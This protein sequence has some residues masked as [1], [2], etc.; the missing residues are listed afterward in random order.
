M[1]SPVRLAD[2]ASPASQQLASRAAGIADDVPSALELAVELGRSV[3][4]PGSRTL[5]RWETLATLGAADLTAARVVEPHLDALAILD[6]AA[7][8]GH[9]VDLEAI[10]AD[11]D[12]TWGVFAAEGPGPGV[13]A[14]ARGDGW[15][16]HGT[17]PWCSLAD[18][19]SHA[20]LT[21]EAPEGRG[22]FAVSLRGGG[23][24]IP[25]GT[26][27]ARGLA[28]V[29]SGPVVIDEVTAVPVGPARWY[30]ERPGFAW[31]GIGVAAAWFGG[32]V[33]IARRLFDHGAGKP[34]DPLR[35]AA[36]GAVDTALSGAAAVLAASAAE[37]DGGSPDPALLAARVRGVVAAAV[38]ITLIRA[39]HTLGPAP[40]ALDEVHARR[41]A[42]LTLYVRQHH[43]ER[44]DAALG[45]ALV[46]KAVRPW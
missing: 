2:S 19:L 20:L 40:L 6:E 43:A 15:T 10:G 39:G 34:G 45:A 35:L 44:D 26:W 7:A 3:A 30:L 21:A 38:E 12:S 25:T 23:I 28:A 16:L 8:A 31:G 33:G 1:S 36:L 9:P 24:D 37:I 14:T 17:K 29:T 46:K 32:A 42:D 11:A 27:V 18:R 41:V 5:G 22:L 13:V 4:A